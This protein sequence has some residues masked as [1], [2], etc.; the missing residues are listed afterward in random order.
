MAEI[1][2]PDEKARLLGYSSYDEQFKFVSKLAEIIA[3]EICFS[4]DGGNFQFAIPSIEFVL[5]RLSYFHE[6]V[7]EIGAWDFFSAEFLEKEFMMLNKSDLE[8]MISDFN[9][10]FGEGFIALES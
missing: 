1:L 4:I 2:N 3:S 6:E 8:E 5:N 10:Y 7:A 9:S